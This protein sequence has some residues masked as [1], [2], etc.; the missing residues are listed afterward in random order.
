[1]SAFNRSSL[2]AWLHRHN[3][4]SIVIRAQR[5]TLAIT[6][7]C[8]GIEDLDA[9]ST[10]FTVCAVKT[11]LPNGEVSLTLHDTALS[12][13]VLLRDPQGGQTAISV[14]VT[15]AYSELILELEEE[16][17]R[18][19]RRPKAEALSTPYRLLH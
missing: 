10:E 14:P 4:Q 5:S 1:M 13:H 19:G 12:L 7:V 18:K 3:G 15:V 2:L 16:R 8:E 11:S 6:G 9:C 17:R